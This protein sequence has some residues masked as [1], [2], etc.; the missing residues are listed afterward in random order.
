MIDFLVSLEAAKEARL[1]A[2]VI[3]PEIPITLTAIRLLTDGPSEDIPSN[4]INQRVLTL[5]GINHYFLL[6]KLQFF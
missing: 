6:S 2:Q 4:L 3:P 1:Y 5:R